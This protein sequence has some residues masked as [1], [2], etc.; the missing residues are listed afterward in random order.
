MEATDQQSV[1]GPL[2]LRVS[3]LEIWG[4]TRRREELVEVPG[5]DAWVYAEPSQQAAFGGDIHYVSSCAHG[6][7]ARFSLLDVA[8]HGSAVSDLAHRVR[9]LM[10][11]HINK[12]DQTEFARVI[13]Q[14]FSALAARGSFATAMFT[15]FFVPTRHLVMINAGHPR[16]LLYRAASGTWQLL[17]EDLGSEDG[18]PLNLPLGI[19]SPTQYVQFAVNLELD[20]VV[21][22]YTDGLLDAPDGSGGRLGEAGLLK[23]VQRV[24]DHRP[25]FLG[26]AIREALRAFAGNHL[27]EDDLSIIVLRANGSGPPPRSMAER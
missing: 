22:L 11:K 13:N 16:P 3:C 14:E 26:R 15:T 20:D 4:G 6:D 18:V 19:I 23:L 12:V 25:A 21:L 9:R 17:A 8:G 7:I 5:L 24:D 1:E 2:A 27:L 10:R